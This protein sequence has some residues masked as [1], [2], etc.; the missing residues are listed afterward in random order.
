RRNMI[1]KRD[2]SSDVCSSDLVGAD[3]KA[4]EIRCVAYLS[5]EPV[6]VNAFIDG[7]DPYA[8]MASRFYNKPYEEVYKNADGS[9][10]KERKEMKVVWL[11]TLYGM[12]IY[13]LADMLGVSKEEAERFQ[14]ELFDSMPKLKKIGRASCR[15]G[16]YT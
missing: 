15:E 12:S 8:N 16:V 5:Q 6:L 10:T 1:S 4:Q 9:D 11:A 3:F 14:E 13:S 7:V 2:W